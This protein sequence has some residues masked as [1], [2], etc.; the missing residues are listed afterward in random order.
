MQGKTDEEKRIAKYI[1]LKKR[2]DTRTRRTPNATVTK[3]EKFNGENLI[4]KVNNR[5]IKLYLI[6]KIL[7]LARGSFRTLFTIA[8]IILQIYFAISLVFSRFC[9]FFR[10]SALFYLFF[11]FWCGQGDY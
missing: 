8:R 9:L 11:G 4:L 3:I 6:K 10:L 5:Y 7:S 2:E 1:F